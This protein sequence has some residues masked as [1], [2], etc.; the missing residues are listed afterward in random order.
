LAN[1][2]TPTAVSSHKTV[3]FY[4]AVSGTPF[5][6][7]HTTQGTIITYGNTPSLNTWVDSVWNTSTYSSE[8]KVSSFSSGDGDFGGGGA[9]LPIQFLSFVAKS[10]ANNAAE[11]NW[12]MAKEEANAIYQVQRSA[13]G[14]NWSTLKNIET[15]NSA[16]YNYKDVTVAA[17]G[18]GNYYRIAVIAANGTITYSSLQY[19]KF[20]GDGGSGITIS[21]NPVKTNLFIENLNPTEVTTFNVMDLSGKILATYNNNGQTNTTLDLNN[22]SSGIYLLS[23]NEMG[24]VKNIKFVKE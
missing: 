22:L 6:N 4:K 20:D 9:P 11:L 17:T 14:R 19:V 16:N 18:M 21:P 13:N 12:V 5:A 10:S 23:I 24:Q 3:N 15:E 2:V 8:F 1:F 7:P